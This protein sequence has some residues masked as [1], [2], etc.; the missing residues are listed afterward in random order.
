MST[1]VVYSTVHSCR[2]LHG[3]VQWCKSFFCSAGKV[4][5]KCEWVA[6]PGVAIQQDTANGTMNSLF[7]TSENV[8]DAIV[9]NMPLSPPLPPEGTNNSKLQ[10]FAGHQRMRFAQVRALYHRIHSKQ[11]SHMKPFKK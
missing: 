1:Q 2:S 4:F 7:E 8:A 10:K 9:V 5:V 11:G 3:T 6:V